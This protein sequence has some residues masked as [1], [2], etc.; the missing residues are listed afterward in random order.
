[1]QPL[2]KIEILVSHLKLDLSILPQRE[3]EFVLDT[4]SRQLDIK[5][6]RI[7]LD[8]HTDGCTRFY[9]EGFRVN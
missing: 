5:T 9:A 6:L 8:P 2:S 7:S 3:I 1:M 4:I